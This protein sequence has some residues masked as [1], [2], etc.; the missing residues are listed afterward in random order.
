MKNCQL[1]GRFGWVLVAALLGGNLNVQA[2]YAG[3]NGIFAEFYTS[4]GNFTNRLEFT[5]APKAC[6]NF[7]GLATGERAWLDLPSGMVKANPFFTGTTFHRVIAGFM[8]QGGSPNALG[9]DGPG[10]AF[11]D[12]F[13]PALRH[14][15]FGVL[16]SANSGLDSN[17]SQYFVTAEP[18]PWLDDVHTVFGKLFGGSN[19]VYA[20]NHVATGLN[21]KPLTNVLVNSV[22]IQRIGAAAQAFDIH[23]QGLP[24]V[25]NLNLKISANGG[26]GSLVFSNRPYAD[27]RLYTSTNL[28]N[29]SGQQ[30]AIE[31]GGTLTNV[32]L[33]SI[34]G[35]KSFF[36]AAQIQYPTST[37]S[38][39][40]LFG[41][42]LT[43]TFTSGR[44]GVLVINF[45]SAGGGSY[46]YNSSPG[47]LLGYS[48]AQSPYNGQLWPIGFVGPIDLDM[49]L[50]LNFTNATGGTL[51]GTEYG[52]PFYY[53]YSPVTNV[54]G[55]VFLS[56]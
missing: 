5:V 18:T 33:Q 19:V 30:L 31:V 46:N 41:R 28:L 6:A 3:T 39:K 42:I 12:E 45:N 29:W 43:I 36:R 17:G 49:T 53:P 25:T 56:P 20:I 37:F 7:I 50:K 48:W 52:A 23:S 54:V 11:E 22:V 9:T 47:N 40:N 38:P 10:Y 4:L 15:S 27:N 51:T 2:Q 16:S 35:P 21:D 32:V 24:L 55:N 14:N 1:F 34:T 44:S 26:V 13:S 8:V